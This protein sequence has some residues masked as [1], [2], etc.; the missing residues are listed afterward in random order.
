MASSGVLQMYFGLAPLPFIWACVEEPFAAPEPDK[1]KVS[2]LQLANSEAVTHA[3][4]HVTVT[5]TL[6]HAEANTLGKT[7]NNLYNVQRI[8]NMYI[9]ATM[10]SLQC[11]ETSKN[12]N[13]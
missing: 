10:T 7:Q 2:R 8:Y 5:W 12:I 3:M 4:L 1:L 6:Q 11:I 9:T 13:E